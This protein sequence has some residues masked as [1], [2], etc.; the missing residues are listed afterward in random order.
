MDFQDEFLLVP[1]HNL[2]VKCPTRRVSI[3]NRIIKILNCVIRILARNFTSLLCT[4]VFDTLVCLEME[5][6]PVGVFIVVVHFKSV[7]SIP[8]H[9]SVTIR[10]S[11][12]TEQEHHLV[13]RLRSQTDE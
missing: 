10:C 1:L 12:V 4:Q 5:L 13:C 8:V 11:P 3:S 9:M 6:A 7:T 2:Q